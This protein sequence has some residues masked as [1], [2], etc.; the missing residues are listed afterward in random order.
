MQTEQK[1]Q[2]LQRVFIN[3]CFYFISF[4]STTLTV[5]E[6]DL[7]VYVRSK[8]LPKIK[9]TQ[10]NKNCWYRCTNS[11]RFNPLR[12]KQIHSTIYFKERAKMF[13][14]LYSNIPDVK[15]FFFYSSKRHYKFFFL[16]FRIKYM[17]KKHFWW[18]LSALYVPIL[19]FD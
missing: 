15:R 18:I 4:Y 13:W 10:P 11:K 8:R 3:T 19:N 14:S 2:Q 16:L 7:Y 17:K 12:T 6:W 9:Q 5:H 1:K